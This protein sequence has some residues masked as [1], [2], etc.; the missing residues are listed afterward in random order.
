MYIPASHAETDPDTLFAFLAANPLGALVTTAANGELVASHIPWVVHR[1]GGVHSAL[2]GHI[3]RANSGHTA[4]FDVAAVQHMQALVIFTGPDAYISPTWYASKSE[5][6]KVV[7]TWNY[8]AVHV[9]GKARFTSDEEFLARHLEQLVATH[10]A[11]RPASWSVRDAPRDYIERQMRAIV[12]VE[13]AID[14]IE[15]KWK[16]SQNR[17]AQDVAA[18]IENLRNSQVVKDRAVG[19]IVAARN[20]GRGR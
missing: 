9:Y 12:G 4:Q 5:H 13:V 3:A 6:G 17:P 8:V 11:A 1:A 2:H 10:E 16:M 20:Q 15:G 18:V 14:R 19:E 7:P